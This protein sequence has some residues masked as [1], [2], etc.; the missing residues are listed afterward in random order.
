MIDRGTARGL[1]P[2]PTSAEAAVVKFLASHA[3][4]DDAWRDATTA[5][6]SGRSERALEEW[7]EWQ[8]ERFQL[9]GRKDLGADSA[10]VRVFFEISIDGRSDGGE[11]EFE[12]AREA[13][14][15]RVT[16]PPT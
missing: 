6:P 7:E 2:A 11:D 14:G 5:S 4:A 3:R 15:W 16:Q 13:G 9:R 8:L 10:Y 12:V 1:D